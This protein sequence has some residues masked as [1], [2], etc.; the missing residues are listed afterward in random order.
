[1]GTFRQGPALRVNEDIHLRSPRE[2]ADVE[3]AG[4]ATVVREALGAS[5]LRLVDIDTM[6][7]KRWRGCSEHRDHHH[8][9]GH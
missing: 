6:G 9:G 3:E 4:P 1:V 7:G 8:G 5:S 2:Y